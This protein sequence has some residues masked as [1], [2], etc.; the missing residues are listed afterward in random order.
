MRLVREEGASYGF[1]L[2]LTSGNE[3]IVSE[4]RDGTRKH[5]SGIIM[6]HFHIIGPAK[7]K[8]QQDDLII[9]IN[10]ANVADLSY[11]EVIES[12]NSTL[13]K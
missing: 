12:L 1:S 6:T 11:G 4:V 13:I 8:L 9:Q 7:G 5:R 2:G 10:G 3:F